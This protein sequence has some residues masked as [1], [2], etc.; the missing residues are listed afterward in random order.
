M[1][2]KKIA[3]FAGG[4]NDFPDPKYPNLFVFFAAPTPGHSPEEIGK[5][6]QVEVERLKTE[7]ISDEELK[8]IR[9]R[10]KANLLRQLADNEGLAQQL[11]TMQAL[12]GDWRELFKQVENLDKV[13]KADIRRVANQ[14]FVA[15]NR[16][17]GTIETM[18]PTA[19]ASQGVQQ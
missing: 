5:A 1:R 9:T 3:A 17:V 19:A 18:R 6:I 11:G 7:D 2:D 8:M 12:F 16:T 13:T 4:F 14:T 15:S 10:A